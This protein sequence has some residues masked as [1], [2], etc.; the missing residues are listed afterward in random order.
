[1]IEFCFKVD[2]KIKLNNMKHK[3]TKSITLLLGLGLTGLQAQNATTASGGEASG[4]G[5][6]QSYSIGQVAYT[7]VFGSTGSVAQGVQQPYEISVITEIGSAKEIDLQL[8]TYPNPTTDLLNLNIGNL[9]ASSLSYQLFD[10][11][12]KLLMSSLI[13]DVETKISMAHLQDAIYFFKIIENT[14]EIKS[15][16]IIKN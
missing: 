7:T 12:G 8:S 2:L 10:I 9:K 15:F 3:K 11:N 1:M 13:S 6:T 16:K 14:T 4:S 5:G